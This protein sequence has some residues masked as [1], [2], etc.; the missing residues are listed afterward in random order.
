MIHEISNSLNRRFRATLN[1]TKSQHKNNH[2]TKAMVLG[3]QYQDD[4][5][6]H[7]NVLRKAL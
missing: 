6:Y 3:P 2:A 4:G 5:G 1:I 7:F